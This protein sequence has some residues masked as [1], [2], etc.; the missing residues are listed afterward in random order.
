MG[1]A[2]ALQHMGADDRVVEKAAEIGVVWPAPLDAYSG[3]SNFNS[4]VPTIVANGWQA[5]GP[6]HVNARQDDQAPITLL[7]RK[8]AELSNKL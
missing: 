3:F 8:R 6:E 4:F 7:L 2:I 1:A 5:T